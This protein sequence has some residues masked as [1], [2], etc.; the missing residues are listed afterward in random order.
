M[1]G[2]SRSELEARVAALEA[3]NRAL[4]SETD[5]AAAP[6]TRR[7]G[8]ELARHSTARHDAAR[9]ATHAPRG[10]SSASR[11]PPMAGTVATI[12]PITATART[13]HGMRPQRRRAASLPRPSRR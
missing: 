11:M 3:E 9:I 5:A 6:S 13:P 12:P 2:M 10:W 7:N 1:A 8:I 4:R